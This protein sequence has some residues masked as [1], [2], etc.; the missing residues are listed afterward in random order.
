MIHEDIVGCST[1]WSRWRQEG[2]WK[3]SYAKV[4]PRQN[5]ALFRS[6]YKHEPQV[7]FIKVPGHELSIEWDDHSD[8]QQFQV[9]L[10]VNLGCRA[11]DLGLQKGRFG[12]S[13]VLIRNQS[14]VKSGKV[15]LSY[16]KDNM[17]SKSLKMGSKN[18]K[19]L[20]VELLES[21]DLHNFL[22][23]FH[24]FQ[25]CVQA[26]IS[27]HWEIE[28]SS[29]LFCFMGIVMLTSVYLACIFQI[30]KLHEHLHFLFLF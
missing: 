28:G 4:K 5:W 13:V 14:K 21:G 9:T 23:P 3:P 7:G 12:T 26:F 29:D 1:A 16:M 30:W 25:M 27:V 19:G 17:V 8:F 24:R 11:E 20:L 22:L 15:L 18:E 10:R 6:D 2:R